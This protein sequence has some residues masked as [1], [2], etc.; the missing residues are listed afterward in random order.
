M[1]FKQKYINIIILLNVFAY[2]LFGCKSYNH[3]ELKYLDK[4]EILPGYNYKST[5]IGGLSG[6]DF[7]KKSNQYYLV[8]DDK[9]EYNFAR[10]YKA[11][12]VINNKKIDTLIFTDVIPIFNKDGKYIDFQ[13]SD[14]ES[15][16]FNPEKKIFVLGDEGGKYNKPS[17][18]IIDCNGNFIRNLDLDTNYVNQTRS[19]NSFESISFSDDYKSIFYAT[20][21]PLFNDGEVSSLNNKGLIRI[22]ES[23]F[24]NGNIKKE[25]LFWLN[26]VPYPAAIKPP[27]K[28]TGSDNGLSEILY[29]NNNQML[30]LERSGAYQK[31]GSFNFTCKL[32]S[33]T[34]KE[35][36]S[37]IL[38][39]SKKDE[40][41]NFSSLP[42]KS[43]NI[44]GMTLGPIIDG[45][46]SIFFISDN[47]FKND[48]SV[49]YLF[50]LNKKKQNDKQ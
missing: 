35:T 44:E 40:I 25:T 37:K 21:A 7:D 45:D 39:K 28:G 11:N 34:S 31:D 36:N 9:S 26:K 47:N 4:Y 19:N 20:E 43:T 1:N 33:L 8:T 18:R 24:E 30:I 16:R 2:M 50:T 27:W 10:L 48:A 32:F 5:L 42:F 15:I 29:L 49:I 46:Q 17:I 12:I 3:L 41:F 6:I 23:D 14:F 38:R 13:N 22:I